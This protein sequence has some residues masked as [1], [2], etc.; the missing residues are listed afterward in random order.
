MI[1]DIEG[2]LGKT[3]KVDGNGVSDTKNLLTSYTIV[4]AETHEEV[5]SAV[6]ERQ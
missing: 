3:K 5:A 6:S 4:E 2:P 1:T